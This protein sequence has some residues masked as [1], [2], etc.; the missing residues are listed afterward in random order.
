MCRKN[1]ISFDDNVWGT[2]FLFTS[3]A[4]TLSQRQ[5]QRRPTACTYLY[6][7]TT[8][9]AGN[10][11]LLVNALSP[12]ALH[13]IPILFH[14]RF[15]RWVSMGLSQCRSATWWFANILKVYTRKSV[16][17]NALPWPNSL[18]TI[19]LRL[20]GHFVWPSIPQYGYSRFNPG[21]V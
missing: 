21:K 6:H 7:L 13:L 18:L 1:W 14:C 19:S 11:L 12:K 3:L 16:L 2:C 5:R 15:E 9:Y 8:N 17:E 20:E 10:A 4:H